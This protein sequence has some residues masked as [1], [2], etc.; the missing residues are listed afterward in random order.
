MAK[1][2]ATIDEILE[3][4]TRYFE[5]EKIPVRNLAAVDEKTARGEVKI[6]SLSLDIPVT[7][8]F[9]SFMKPNVLFKLVSRSVLVNKLFPIVSRFLERYQTNIITLK[10][11]YLIVDTEAAMKKVG[12]MIR[13]LDVQHDGEKFL[14]DIGVRHV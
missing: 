9:D 12:Q 6:P 5:A 4:Y 8:T 13:I 11:P 10:M 3:L 1:V 14:I 2:E 7:V